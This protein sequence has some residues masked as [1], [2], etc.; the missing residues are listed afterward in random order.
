MH[1]MHNSLLSG[2]IGYK[3]TRENTLMKYYWYGIRKDIYHWVQQCDQCE[4]TKIPPKS[5]KAPLGEMPTGA[6]LDRLTTDFLGPFPETPKGNRYIL[7]VTD[8]FTKWV[9][10]FATPDQSAKTTTT[11]ILNEVI[12]RFGCPFDLLSNQGRNYESTIF[13]ELCNM[14]AIR[15]L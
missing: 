1:Q 10:I 13:T 15:K 2:H 8:S 12:A 11:V 14:L 6:P 3:K 9:E 5:P 4:K 7:V